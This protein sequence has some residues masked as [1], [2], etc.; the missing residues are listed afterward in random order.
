MMRTSQAEGV[1]HVRNAQ[2]CPYHTSERGV[3]PAKACEQKNCGH[4]KCSQ[5]CT[6]PQRRLAFMDGDSVSTSERREV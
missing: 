1:A 3:A 5:G 2:P 4:P 6:L